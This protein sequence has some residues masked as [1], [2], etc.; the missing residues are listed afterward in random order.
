M[1]QRRLYL[2]LALLCFALC[3]LVATWLAE[4]RFLRGF[5]GDVLVVLLIYFLARGLLAQPPLPLALGVLLFAWAIE[6]LQALHAAD[7]LGL[8]GWPRIILGATFDPWDLAAYALGALI[9]CGTDLRILRWRAL[10]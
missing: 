9:A 4:L 6:G 7:V 8:Q 5:A 2:L 3:L 1:A 10:H